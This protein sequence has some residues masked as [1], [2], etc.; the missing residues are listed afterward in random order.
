M[1]L[2]KEDKSVAV[3]CSDSRGSGSMSDFANTYP[4]QFVEVG[5][6]EQSLAAGMAAAGMKPVADVY[7]DGNVPFVMDKANVIRRGGDA[8]II[9]CGEMVLDAK[10]AGEKLAAEGVQVTVIDMYCIKPL[11][12]KAVLE[13][14]KD[15]L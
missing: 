6:A 7:E 3:L 13:A 12:V 1:E 15:L 11:D 9:A 8:A 2:A 5:I 10:E 14:A 4:E